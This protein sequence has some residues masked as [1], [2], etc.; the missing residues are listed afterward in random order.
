ME[1]LRKATLEDFF[2]KSSDD[3]NIRIG[4]KS[5]DF[6]KQINHDYG[7]KKFIKP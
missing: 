4:K 7:Q 1:N 6:K 3:N 2:G 5:T